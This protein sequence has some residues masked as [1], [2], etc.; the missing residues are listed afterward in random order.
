MLV[1]RKSCV[2]VCGLQVCSLWDAALPHLL[3]HTHTRMVHIFH[4][5]LGS[6]FA[7]QT[8]SITALTI[9]RKRQE[10]IVCVCVF[11]CVCVCVSLKIL[12]RKDPTHTLFLFFTLKSCARELCASCH[13]KTQFLKK[14]FV[15]IYLYTL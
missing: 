12:G 8:T 5:Y 2:C 11:F 6:L 3:M 14:S 15:Q 7:F 13:L 4:F 1:C 10:G 9:Y